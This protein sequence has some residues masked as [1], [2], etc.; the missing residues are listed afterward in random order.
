VDAGYG[1]AAL[2]REL[3]AQIDAGRVRVTGL[4]QKDHLSLRGEEDQEPYRTGNVT[5]TLRFFDQSRC[6]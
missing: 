4:E 5:L 6:E 3:A 2:L 1:A